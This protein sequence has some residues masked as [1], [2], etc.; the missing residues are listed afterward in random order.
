MSSNNFAYFDSFKKPQFFFADKVLITVLLCL[1]Q[2]NL[3]IIHV[4]IPIDFTDVPFCTLFKCL[5]SFC[6]FVLS[7]KFCIVDFLL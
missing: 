1:Q 5:H 4:N 3:T 7:E 6:Y 2:K